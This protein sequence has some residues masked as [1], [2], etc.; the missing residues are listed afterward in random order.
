MNKLDEITARLLERPVILDT[1]DFGPSIWSMICLFDMQRRPVCTY[2]YR[3]MANPSLVTTQREAC[4]RVRK[5]AHDTARMPFIDLTT[6][7]VTDYDAAARS[8][9]F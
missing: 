1:A 9:T 2:A 8:K 3:D 7:Y 4:A 6:G 5:Y